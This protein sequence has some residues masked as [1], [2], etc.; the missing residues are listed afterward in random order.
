MPLT[1]DDHLEVDIKRHTDPVVTWTDAY[2]DLYH[3]IN[4]Y[5]QL[6]DPHEV[7][8]IVDAI[9]EVEKLRDRLDDVLEY[10]E[11]EVR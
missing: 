2:S 9:L 5:V 3:D 7:V 6:K 10:L 8:D 1:Y 11:Y 4:T